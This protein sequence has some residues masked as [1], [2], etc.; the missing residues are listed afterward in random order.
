MTKIYQV[1][2]RKERLV[3]QRK[4]VCFVFLKNVFLDGIFFENFLFIIL[5][6]VGPCHG[7][8]WRSEGGGFHFC[9]CDRYQ[10]KQQ[11][12]GGGLIPAYSSSLPSLRGRPGRNSSSRAHLVHSQEQCREKKKNALRLPA[13]STSFLLFYIVQQPLPRKQCCPQWA[14]SSYI[15]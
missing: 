11:H 6:V 9:C 1:A 13:H 10:D 12:K 8:Q 2:K 7:L 4:Q 14:R 3:R 15:D 5:V